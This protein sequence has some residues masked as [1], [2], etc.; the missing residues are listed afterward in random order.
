MYGAFICLLDSTACV[1]QYLLDVYYGY[2]FEHDN[3]FNIT[4]KSVSTI[5]NPNFYRPCLLTV[6]FG[7][8]ALEYISST[9]YLGFRFCYTNN[10]NNDMLR[11]MRP[12]YAKS[13]T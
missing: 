12:V 10:D 8:D 9:K 4:I 1:M 5:F 2:T 13:N 11:E 6:S 7:Y 3:I